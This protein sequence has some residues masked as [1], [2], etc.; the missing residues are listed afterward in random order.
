ME[1]PQS[2]QSV[3]PENKTHFLNEI[4]KDTVIPNKAE[5]PKVLNTNNI[6]P[7]VKLPETTCITNVEKCN[8]P[9][10]N[11]AQE[12]IND[13]VEIDYEEKSQEQIIQP[14]VFET[15]N[16]LFTKTSINDTMV[17]ANKVIEQMDVENDTDSSIINEP[18]DESKTDVTDML[19]DF[20]DSD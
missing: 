4:I 1:I 19:K 12:I 18:L 5:K 14:V 13:N 6:Q 16:E 20:I 8:S 15:T 3:L 17:Q 7:I 9:I 10:K 11:I 2:I